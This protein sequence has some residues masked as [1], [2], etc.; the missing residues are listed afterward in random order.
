M[1]STPTSLDTFSLNDVPIG[2]GKDKEDS[3]DELQD[4]VEDDGF[5]RTSF[6]TAEADV[7]TPPMT[8]CGATAAQKSPR[9]R[10]AISTQFPE[11][12]DYCSMML[13]NLRKC[14]KMR[15]LDA[16]I[17][18]DTAENEARKE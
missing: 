4:S 17:G 12:E 14:C 8:S 7:N 11:S 2:N 16:E 13:Q 6:K 1:A 5:E 18:V 10:P 9:S 3:D 15:I